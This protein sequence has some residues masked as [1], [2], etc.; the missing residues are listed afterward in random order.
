[1]QLE[2]CVHSNKRGIIMKALLRALLLASALMW[3]ALPARAVTGS[4]HP[5]AIHTYVGLAV[6]YDQKGEFMYRCSGSLLAPRI[7]LTAGHCT[8]D[9]ENPSYA[10]IY[11]HQGAGAHYDP[12]T[13][14][15]PVT[16]YPEKCI[17]GD[18]LCVTG[19]KLYDY[20]FDNFAG[21]PNTHD[22]GIIVLD[23]PVTF[24]TSY[25]SLA[26]PGSLDVLSTRRGVQNVTFTVSG[27]GVSDN[28]PQTKPTVSFRERLMATAMLQNLRNVWTG[29][30]NIQLSSAQ[31]NDRGGI[32][33]GDS[34]GPA[35]WDDT[36]IIAGVTS[37]GKHEQCL[38]NG[39]EYRVDQQDLID[40]ILKIAATVGESDMISVVPLK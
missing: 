27:Y 16:G 29:G 37:F 31:G 17:A 1:V 40:W 11:F 19:H 21:F 14:L 26:K 24:A 8:D 15:D 13:Q 2:Q 28:W 39:Y 36:D 33:S 23:A 12:A 18:P 38:G 4:Y 32:C 22:A 20:G 7:F 30:F 5:D 3:A 6:F 34:G 25:A 10:R 35:L 9:A